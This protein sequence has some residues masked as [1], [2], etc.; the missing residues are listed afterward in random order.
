ME[1][2]LWWEK[3]LVVGKMDKKH[4]ENEKMIQSCETR[5]GQNPFNIT[6]LWFFLAFVYG[7]MC[8]FAVDSVSWN[9]KNDKL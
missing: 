8:R 3:M 1:M 5:M 4:E 2:R 6:W 7:C 9:A